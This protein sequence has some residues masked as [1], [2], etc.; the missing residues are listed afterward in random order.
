MQ[1]EV[2]SPEVPTCIASTED[3]FPFHIS[4]GSEVCKSKLLIVS[5]FPSMRDVLLRSKELQSPA[6]VGSIPSPPFSEGGVGVSVPLD[7]WCN[8]SGPQFFICEWE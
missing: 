1:R 2:V 6:D 7:K 5:E 3:L 4:F 8:L